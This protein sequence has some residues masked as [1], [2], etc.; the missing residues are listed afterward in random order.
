MTSAQLHL[1][2]NNIIVL[3]ALV[4]VVAGT[5]FIA[6]PQSDRLQQA[7][8]SLKLKQYEVDRLTK[9]KKTLEDLALQ[10]PQYQEEVNKLAIAYPIDEQAIEALIQT[11]TI[12]D[13]SSIAVTDIAPSKGTAGLLP[14]TLSTRGSYE[15]FTTF[16]RELYA[17]LRPTIVKSINFTSN[18]EADKG[19][20]TGS[21]TLNFAYDGTASVTP[22]PSASLGTSPQPL[23]SR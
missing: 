18:A 1:K 15:S 2:P 10:L 16:F 8:Q 7:T 14:V 23:P 21:L 12:A 13:R 17:N 5:Y 9:Q 20:L 4:V 22:T 11:K 3:V 19:N 6:K